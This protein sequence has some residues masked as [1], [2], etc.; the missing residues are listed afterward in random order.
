VMSNIYRIKRR[1]TRKAGK[2]G[3]RGRDEKEE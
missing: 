1:N 2:G 3:G